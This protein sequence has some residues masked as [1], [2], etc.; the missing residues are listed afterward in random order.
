M[1]AKK[2][3]LA[4]TIKFSR[5]GFSGSVYVEPEDYQGFNALLVTVHGEHPPKRILPGNTR[6]YFVIEGQG[7]F[8]LN[9]D[10]HTVKEGDLFVVPADN[11]YCYRG[12]M[13]LF[14]FN[15]SADNSF[16]DQ[17]VE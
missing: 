13:K 11:E 14:E 17:L 6:C 8:V 16:G 4:D 7:T 3:S 9:E 12:N 10:K 15:I 1:K 2:L 5:E